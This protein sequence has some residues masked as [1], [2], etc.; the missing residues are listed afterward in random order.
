[1]IEKANNPY[2]SLTGLVVPVYR[3]VANFK[4]VDGEPKAEQYFVEADNYVRLYTGPARRQ[5]IFKLSSKA[6][7]MFL[8]I[9]YCMNHDYNYVVLSY[10]KVNTMHHEYGGVGTKDLYKRTFKDTIKELIAHNMLDVKDVKKE[11]Y[12]IN[13]AYFFPGSRAT[14]Y[15]DNMV[16]VNPDPHAIGD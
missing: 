1:M 13:P 5:H 12:W 15:P 10:N 6:R 16:I 11:T 3:K 4:F 2:E 14:R 7:D 9:L 8:L